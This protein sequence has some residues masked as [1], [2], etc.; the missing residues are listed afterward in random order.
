MNQA[1][2]TVDLVG[3]KLKKTPV[4]SKWTLLAKTGTYEEERFRLN[5]VEFLVE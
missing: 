4:L 5:H 1:S 3:L 2:E